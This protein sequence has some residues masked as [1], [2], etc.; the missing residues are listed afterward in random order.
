MAI[1]WLSDIGLIPKDLRTGSG[2]H[3]ERIWIIRPLLAVGGHRPESF[4]HPATEGRRTMRP[5]MRLQPAFVLVQVFDHDLAVVDREE[6][7][8]NRELG[9]GILQRTPRA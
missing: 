3:H 9:A 7:V 1:S 8:A 2:D 5:S 4:T 6:Q